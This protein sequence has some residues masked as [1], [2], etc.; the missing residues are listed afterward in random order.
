M[1]NDVKAMVSVVALV[2]AVIFAWWERSYGLPQLFW[3]AIGLAVF[4]VVSM[5]VFPEAVVK[6]GDMPPKQ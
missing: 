5:W 4:A 2:V 3:V 1:P 6:K